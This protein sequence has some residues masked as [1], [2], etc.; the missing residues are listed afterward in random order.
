[1]TECAHTQ[2]QHRQIY[3]LGESNI[4]HDKGIWILGIVDQS[5]HECKI[6]KIPFFGASLVAQMVKNLLAMQETRL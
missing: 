4:H 3:L 2:T 5:Y 1:M 6:Q